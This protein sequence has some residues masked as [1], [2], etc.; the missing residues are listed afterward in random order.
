MTTNTVDTS[1]SLI[2]ARL[3]QWR[4]IRS[5]WLVI[6]PTNLLI[7]RQRFLRKPKKARNFEL[8]FLRAV[9]QDMAHNGVKMTFEVLGGETYETFSFFTGNDADIVH[10]VL[11]KLLKE[12]EERKRLQEEE[13]TRARQREREERQRQVHEKFVQ[14][15]W[16][17]SETLWSLVKAD[18][19]MAN[20]VI[21]GDWNEAKRQYSTVWQQADRLKSTHQ[22]ELATPLQELDE[23]MCEE[24]GEEAIKKAG[25]V[26]EHLANAVLQT[27]AF[28]ETWRKNE[29][30]A[31]PIT[32]NWNHVPYFLLFSARYFETLLSLKIEDW[33][34]VSNGVSALLSIVDILRQCYKID[35]DGLLD[36]AK[37]ATEGRDAEL[38]TE[39]AHRLE[40]ILGASFKTRHFEYMNLGQ[41]ENGENNITLP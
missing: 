13:V 22:I 24:N 10:G 2:K 23:K 5:G 34:G 29:N 32:P 30:I 12:A 38:L 7:Y 35:L 21:A 31:F 40:S 28:W 37:S 14:D 27:D 25:L 11:S 18:Y 26:L 4:S 39:T 19:S 41:K 33:I 6:E 17:T 9:E 1:T 3:R 36:M 16:E 15:V 8:E 20:A